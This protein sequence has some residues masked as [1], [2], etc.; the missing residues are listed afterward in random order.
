MRLLLLIQALHQMARF[1][2]TADNPVGPVF[3]YDGDGSY[4]P[5]PGNTAFTPGPS[6]TGGKQ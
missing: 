2:G 1:V 6:N 3:D 5:A 4:E